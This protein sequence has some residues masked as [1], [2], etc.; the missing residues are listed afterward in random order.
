LEEIQQIEKRLEAARVRLLASV[1]GLD[2][3]AWDWQ[4]ADGRW[5]VRL[6]LAHV[7]S[8]HWSHLEVA[9]RIAEGRTV[10]LP[11]FDLDEWNQARVA[12]RADWTRE[13]ILADLQA[14][15]QATTVFMAGLE[16]E[17]L[18]ARGEHPV[19]GEVSADQV[20]RVI[21]LHDSLHR[22]EILKLRREMDALGRTS[23]EGWG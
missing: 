9:R 8:A 11:G 18:E 22:R 4:P 15:Q 7:G 21:A 1:E 19:L 13:Q 17:T 3:A 5:S 6:T 20:L 10:D 12:E 2:E 23:K 16:P 14:A